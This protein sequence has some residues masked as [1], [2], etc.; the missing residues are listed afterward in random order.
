MIPEIPYDFDK[1]EA[2]QSKLRSCGITSVDFSLRRFIPTRDSESSTPTVVSTVVV[3]ISFHPTLNNHTFVDTRTQLGTYLELYG[4]TDNGSYN[5]SLVEY[6]SDGSITVK[7]SFKAESL[8][9]KIIA[10]ADLES[11]NYYEMQ[12]SKINESRLPTST[13]NS[14]EV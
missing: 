14:M 12:K 9:D 8:V 1:D 3:S 10:Q 4:T 11:S 7:D 2:V 6:N 13:R 5:Y